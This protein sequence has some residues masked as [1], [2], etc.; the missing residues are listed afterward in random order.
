MSSVSALK[1]HH[2][3]TPLTICL[4]S[5]F[6]LNCPS[7]IRQGSRLSF[8][9]HLAWMATKLLGQV[10]R[11]PR[12]IRI[13]W[14]LGSDVRAGP[15]HAV[16]FHPARRVHS[17]AG[18]QTASGGVAVCLQHLQEGAGHDRFTHG[19]FVARTALHLHCRSPLNC[20]PHS[21]A[22][23]VSGLRTI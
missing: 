1:S 7:C 12:Y 13:S 15:V 3:H 2:G 14:A 17:H 18:Q 8:A 23:S 22:K 6:C 21:G 4:L 20:V 10:P 5:R 19:P 16:L 9:G 11:K